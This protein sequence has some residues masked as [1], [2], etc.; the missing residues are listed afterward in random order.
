M[1]ADPADAQLKDF[2]S[3]DPTDAQKAVDD[4]KPHDPHDHQ[5]CGALTGHGGRPADD[6]T[7]SGQAGGSSLKPG[8]KE[9]EMPR[10]S[11]GDNCSK[12]CAR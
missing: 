4:R 2:M 6:P 1:S 12:K 9:Q 10:A 11:G 5:L 8:S 7:A 3:A